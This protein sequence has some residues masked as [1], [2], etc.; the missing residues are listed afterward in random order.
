MQID[1]QLMLGPVTLPLPVPARV[2]VSVKVV[3]EKLGVTV[4]SLL[5]LIVHLVPVTAVQPDHESNFQ[6]DLAT[7]SSV[8]DSKPSSVYL[9]EQVEPQ[10]MNPSSLVIVP[11]GCGVTVSVAVGCV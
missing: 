3:R 11:P 1:G 8:T 4:A 2:I 10:L 9:C 6:P 5:N 7:A